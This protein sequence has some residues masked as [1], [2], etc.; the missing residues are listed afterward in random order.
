MKKCLRKNLARVLTLCFILSLCLSAVSYAENE[1]PEYESFPVYFNGL[2][3][4]RGYEVNGEDYISLT[5]LNR[6]LDEKP[7]VTRDEENKIYDINILG[8][9]ITAEDGTG[10]LCANGRYLYIPN[11][12][13]EIRGSVYLPADAL[14]RLLNL[15]VSSTDTGRKKLCIDTHELKPIE[16]GETYYSKFFTESDLY[17]MPRIISSEACNHSLA[18]MIGVGNVVLNRVASEKY[19]NNIEAVVFDCAGGVQFEPTINGRVYDDPSDLSVV[20]AYLCFEGYSL[21]AGSLFFVEP[22]SCDDSW[23]RTALRYVTSIDTHDF[24]DIK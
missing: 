7:S 8:I 21:V 13:V 5:A 14:A 16:D 15:E 6:E 23:F 4:S 11:G 1:E 22:L 20:A 3:T 2:L 9:E 12:I 24:Y 19:P 18:G 17:W 10:Y